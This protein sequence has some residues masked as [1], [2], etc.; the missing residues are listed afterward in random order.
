MASVLLVNSFVVLTKLLQTL[1]RYLGIISNLVLL[2]DLAESCFEDMVIHPHDNI[3][4]HVDQATIS[5]ICKTLIF[6]GLGQTCSCLVI[7][8]KIQ[9]RVHHAR[10]TDSRATTNTDQQGIRVIAKLFTQL[11]FKQDHGLV[12]LI[13]QSAGQFFAGL[14]VGIAYFRRD[15]ET[16]RNRQTNGSH[17]SEIGAFTT[18]QRFAFAFAFGLFLAEVV[19]HFLCDHGCSLKKP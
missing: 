5:I 14:V 6:G 15:G 12:D 9:D 7:E 2:L 3:A 8:A 19:N 10:H 18:K 4:K 17:F 1:G 13:H 16:G 11:F